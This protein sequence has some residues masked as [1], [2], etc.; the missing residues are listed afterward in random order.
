MGRKVK[1]N[2]F[3]LV[4]HN[5]YKLVL[6]VSHLLVGVRI[7]LLLLLFQLTPRHYFRWWREFASVLVVIEEV[8]RVVALAVGGAS[9]SSRDRWY[10]P[11]GPL[12][13]QLVKGSFPHNL[14][15]DTFV[16][17]LVITGADTDSLAAS[18]DALVLTRNVSKELVFA[19]VAVPASSCCVANVRLVFDMPPLVVITITYCGKP[20]VTELAL[21]GLLSRMNPNMHLE[22]ASFV[23]NF[24]AD[25]RCTCFGVNADDFRADK[26]LL[27]FLDIF[28]W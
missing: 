17:L 23:E 13:L 12:M 9:R 28:L 5:W 24:V 11:L 15:L 1:S 26:A 16:N 2:V 10:N 21:V 14:L 18:F 8:V 3:P 6:E 20:F 22:V 27:L 4:W 25:F 19:V 7:I